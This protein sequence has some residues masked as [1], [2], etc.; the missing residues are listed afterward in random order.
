M[1]IANSRNS[2]EA[3]GFL[4]PAVC[5]R[6]LIWESESLWVIHIKL[7]ST[8]VDT[9]RVTTGCCW[10][11]GTRAWSLFQLAI[12]VRWC[13][14]KQEARWFSIALSLHFLVSACRIAKYFYSNSSYQNHS[15]LWGTFPNGVF[16]PSLFS[17]K[18]F[19]DDVKFSV[20]VWLNWFITLCCLWTVLSLSAANSLWL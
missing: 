2:S 10:F 12:G 6:W 18:L 5:G 4:P 3:R 14:C 11:R 20:T 17:F 19:R 9:C 15:S 8:P 16:N 7:P 1:A 13:L